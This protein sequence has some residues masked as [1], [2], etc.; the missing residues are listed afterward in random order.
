MVK[1][2]KIVLRLDGEFMTVGISAEKYSHLAGI[3]IID[4]CILKNPGMLAL[5]VVKGTAGG[6]AVQAGKEICGETT[7]TD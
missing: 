7:A 3:E 2:E 5:R 1:S 4:R 6:Q